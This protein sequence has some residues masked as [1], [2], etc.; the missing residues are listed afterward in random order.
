MYKHLIVSTFN[1]QADT[2]GMK[3]PFNSLKK[4]KKPWNKKLLL[5]QSNFYKNKNTA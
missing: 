4:K 5:K 3:E 1:S 2:Y